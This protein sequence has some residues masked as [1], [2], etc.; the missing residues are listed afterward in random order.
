MKL[1]TLITMTGFALA[2]TAQAQEETYASSDSWAFF[3]GGSVGNVYGDFDKTVGLEGWDSP[4][5]TLQLG[6]QK[7]C[8][9]ADSSH[10]SLFLEVGYTDYSTKIIYNTGIVLGTGVVREDLDMEIVPI[11]LNY[12]HE[13]Y[14]SG[15]MNWYLGAG[16]GVAQV[17]TRLSNSSVPS[18]VG[19]SFNDTTLYGHIFAGLNYSYSEAFGVYGGLRYILMSDVD[20]SVLGISSFSDDSPLNSA[21]Q[22]EF[23]VRINF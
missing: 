8:I 18:V 9:D 6:M 21:V 11:T 1:T 2:A 3:A 16:V 13:F 20:F 7:K 14:L 12:K 10:N 22:Y 4:I 19:R 15:E 17:D 5:Y 23:G